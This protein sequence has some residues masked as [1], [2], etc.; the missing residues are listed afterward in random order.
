MFISLLIIKSCGV[1]G[2]LYFMPQSVLSML[3]YAMA[4][5]LVAPMVPL[6]VKA[7]FLVL[8]FSDNL[9]YL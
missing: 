4:V 3:K 9:F 1:F 7:M 2:P 6:A 5:A 8:S